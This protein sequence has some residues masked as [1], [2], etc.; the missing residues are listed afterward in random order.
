MIDTEEKAFEKGEEKGTKWAGWFFDPETEASVYRRILD[1]LME[2][3]PEIMDLCPNPLTGE[4]ADYEIPVLFEIPIG[5][6]WP[7]ENIL[8]AFES[9]FSQGWCLEVERICRLH[10]SEEVQG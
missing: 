1:G 6:E 3:D 10:L 5:G 4:W 7:E 2:G 9:G 8:D